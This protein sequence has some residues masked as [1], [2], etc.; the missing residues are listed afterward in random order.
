MAARLYDYRQTLV[1]GT[2]LCCPPKD[3]GKTVLP[4]QVEEVKRATFDSRRGV[5][6]TSD[7]LGDFYSFALTSACELASSFFSFF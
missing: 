5:T 2:L 4:S 7:D 6:T 1:N 3:F